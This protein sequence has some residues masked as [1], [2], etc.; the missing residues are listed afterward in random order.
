[1][2]YNLCETALQSVVFS[3]YKCSFKLKNASKRHAEIIAILSAMSRCRILLE[4]LNFHVIAMFIVPA[5][6][7]CF[8]G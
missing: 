6:N 4:K 7:C 8:K 5:A 3:E 1:M 2:K